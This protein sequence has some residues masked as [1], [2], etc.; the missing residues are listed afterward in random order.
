MTTTAPIIDTSKTLPR[1]FSL[2][3]LA[4]SAVVSFSIFTLASTTTE[5]GLPNLVGVAVVAFIFYMTSSYIASRAVEGKRKAADRMV[6]GWVTGAF[7]LA[8]I[9]L[10]SLIWTVFSNGINRMDVT[11]FTHSMRNVL[12]EGGGAYHAIIGTLELTG[13]AT[14]ISVPLGLLT[15]IYLVE[16]GKGRLK[17]AVTFFI[18]VMTGIPSIVAG[19]FA[20]SLFLILFGPAGAINGMA[21]AVSLAVLMTPVV[22]RATEEMLKIV[23][24]ELR[25]ASY[26]LGVPKWLTILK[27]VIPTALAGIATGVIIAIA[28]VIGE[29]APLLLAAGF[30]T[31]VNL[32]PLEEKMMTLPVFVYTSYAIQGTDAQSYVDRAWAGALTLMLIVMVL[33]LVARIIS[34]IFSPKF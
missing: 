9:P 10:G 13:I 8:L 12:G 19:L 33:N 20:F 16:Y 29:T 27:V 32:N 11:F 23:P 28:R 18:D 7:T 15:A 2:M 6:T 34:K 26:A 25:E 24:N 4:G 21:G 1:R 3:A 14:A 5:T 31:S 17:N 22:T 30:T